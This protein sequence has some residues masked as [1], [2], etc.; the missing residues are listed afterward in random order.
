M[1][2]DTLKPINI[3]VSFQKYTG[4]AKTYITFHEY[5]TSG[6]E[7]E[8][9]LEFY[10]GHYIQIDIWSKD[11]YTDI[12]KEV[13]DRLKNIGF[14]RLNEADLYESDTG[15]YHK[16]LRFFYLEEKEED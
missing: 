7:Y 10:T 9:D 5:F 12:V 1:I 8:D 6:E 3:P 13:I 15:I 4:K 2:V 16:S 14:K 11:D